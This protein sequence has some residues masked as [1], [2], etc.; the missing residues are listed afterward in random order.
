MRCQEIRLKQ[1][2]QSSLGLSAVTVLFKFKAK[3]PGNVK[4]GPGALVCRE[5]LQLVWVECGVCWCLYVRGLCVS[6]SPSL[7]VCVNTCDSVCEY[8]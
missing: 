7:C 2:K 4:G 5:R 1:K 8:V 6:A 3:A